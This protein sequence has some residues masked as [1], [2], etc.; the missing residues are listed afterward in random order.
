MD[1]SEPMPLD[2]PSISADII[3]SYVTNNVVHRTDLPAL[4]AAV[5]AALHSLAHP[6]ETAPEKPQPALPIRKTITRDFLISLEDGRHYKT[7][8]RHL[9]RIGLTPKQYR[10]KWGLP[11]DYPMV[12]PSYAQKRSELAKTTGLGQ[13]R[14]KVVAESKPE[15][16]E[17]MSAPAEAAKPKRRTRAQQTKAT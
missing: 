14:R 11:S 10:E 1:Q 17:V 15:A 3:A 13:T 2:L 16:E 4:I 12:A 7:L 5:H 9:G 6:K 8:K